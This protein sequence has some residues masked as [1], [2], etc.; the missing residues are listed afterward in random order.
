MRSKDNVITQKILSE[1]ADISRFICD[2]P[3][4]AYY[5]DVLVQKAV[6]MSLINIGELSKNYSEGFFTA[7]KHI[8]WKQIQAMRNIAAHQYGDVNQ[9]IVWDTI[10]VSIPELEKELRAE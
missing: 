6:V 1:I 3:E 2:M 7:H 10:T 9:T 4:E 5:S 8:P